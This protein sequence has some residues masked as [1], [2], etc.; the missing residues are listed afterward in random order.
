MG[1]EDDLLCS[2]LEAGRPLPP[3]LPAAPTVAAAADEDAARRKRRHYAMRD[4]IRGFCFTYGLVLAVFV[5]ATQLPCR[6]AQAVGGLVIELFMAFAGA[7]LGIIFT[8]NWDQ[9]PY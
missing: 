9:I 6:N 3:Q 4:A 8:W 7:S 2:L 1:K 5:L